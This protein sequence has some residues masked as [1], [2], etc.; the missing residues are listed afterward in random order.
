MEMGF[1]DFNITAGARLRVKYISN[2]DLGFAG[3]DLTPLFNWNTKQLFL[4]LEAEYK[5]TK[6]V[7][8]LPR[9]CR[10]FT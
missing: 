1:V 8:A 4:Y 5:N 10:I 2:F 6:G 7:S 3:V 9:V